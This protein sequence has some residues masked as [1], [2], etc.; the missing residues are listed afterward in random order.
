MENSVKQEEQLGIFTN[1]NTEDI[2]YESI[3]FWLRLSLDPDSS[4]G[5]SE[6]NIK[7]TNK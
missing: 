6:I 7:I 4:D 1:A 2:L 3:D 5:D